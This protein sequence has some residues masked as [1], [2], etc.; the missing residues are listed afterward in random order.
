MSDSGHDRQLQATK[1]AVAT[2]RH[3]EPQT[4]R[5]RTVDKKMRSGYAQTKK[6]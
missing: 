6:E 4:V 3:N 2:T 1:K 5:G